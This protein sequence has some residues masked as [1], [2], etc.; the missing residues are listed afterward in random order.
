MNTLFS[1]HTLLFRLLLVATTLSAI[2]ALGVGHAQKQD[3]RTET[4]SSYDKDGSLITTQT[5]Y[6]AQNRVLEKRELKG[7][8]LRKRTR[9]IYP[10][11]FA[12][13]NT[14]TTEYGPDGKTPKSTTNV[15]H[16]NAGNLT[17]TVTTNYDA[18]GKETGGSKRERDPK[19]GKERCYNWNPGKQVYE[20]TPCPPEKTDNAKVETGGGLIKV[21]FNVTGGNVIVRLP[22]DMMAGDTISGTVFEEPGHKSAI[23]DEAFFVRQMYVDMLGR[24]PGPGFQNWL[25]IVGKE[26]SPPPPI[27]FTVDIPENQPIPIIL[28]D[29]D[30]NPIGSITIPPVTL[31]PIPITPPTSGPSSFQIPTIGQQGRTIEIIGPF[32]GNSSNTHLRWCINLTVSDCDKKPESGGT[33]QPVAE[34][35]RKLVVDN[36]INVA[37][38]IQID[39]KEGQTETQGTFR[40]VGVSL[41]APKTSLL[42]GEKTTLTTNVTGLQG[43]TKPV[44]LTLEANGVITM[45]GGMF[46][47]L[48]IPP[49]QVSSDGSYVTTRGITGIQTGGWSATSTVVTQPF[50]IIL[51][52]PDPPQTLLFNSFTGDYIFCSP[53]GKF[54]GTANLKRDGCMVQ[55]TDLEKDHEIKGSLNACTPID[56]S[57]FWLY[58]SP[59]TTV[60]FTTTVVVQPAKTKVYFNP[61]GRPAPPVQD[62]SAFATCP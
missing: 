41:T 8:K 30:G 60:D 48:F 28:K 5:D 44:P 24:D 20:E 32:D 43:I 26:D 53:Q 39:V 31:P 56:T 51:R 9:F 13:P 45:E 38:P 21:E 37:G 7:G 3:V 49:S 4:S 34:S 22:D 33:L 19:T 25:S 16:D 59:G 54:S 36:P 11:G 46:Q 42:R 18:S 17:N 35:P 50:N 40:N 47:Q 27:K 1:S 52:D 62:V 61:L 12:K 2:L 57:R 29:K 55:I 6:D 14:S 23:D 58:R 15:D 10:K